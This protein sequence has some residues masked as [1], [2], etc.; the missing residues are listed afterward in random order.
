LLVAGDRLLLYF[1]SYR[2]SPEQP[3]AYDPKSVRMLVSS[4]A[5]GKN[6][7]EPAAVWPEPIYFYRPRLFGKHFYVAAHNRAP[8]SLD[9]A[10]ALAGHVVSLL[11]SSDGLKWERVSDIFRGKGANETE[12]IFDKDG[13]LTA[14][15]RCEVPRDKAHLHGKTQLARSP[16]PY[17]DWTVVETEEILTTM[18]AFH[19]GGQAMVLSRHKRPDGVNGLS[20]HRVVKDRLTLTARLPH[21][22]GDIGYPGVAFDAAG[23]RALISYY[24]RDDKL[25]DGVRSAIYVSEL[26]PRP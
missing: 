18:T 6:W 8:S 25:P 1:T 4:S 19:A 21:L 10:E 14:L 16:A 5:D 20:I 24:G 2:R 3:K 22:G 17:R 26:Q 9:G 7:S 12:L 13:G 15:V 23:R 11:R